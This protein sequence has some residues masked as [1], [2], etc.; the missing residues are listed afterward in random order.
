V[1]PRCKGGGRACKRYNQSSPSSVSPSLPP[2]SLHFLG[3][4]TGEEADGLHGQAAV[5]AKCVQP[6]HLPHLNLEGEG[7]KRGKGGREGWLV[8]VEAPAR[9]GEACVDVAWR[10]NIPTKGGMKGGVVF[11]RPHAWQKRNCGPVGQSCHLTAP[12]PTRKDQP[13]R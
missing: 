1:L 13:S 12:P 9:G 7:G 4:R 11:T 8:H 2:S 5:S 6:G 3:L 10:A